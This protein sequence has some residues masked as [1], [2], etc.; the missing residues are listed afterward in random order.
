MT[1]LGVTEKKIRVVSG[2]LVFKAL[3]WG[4]LGMVVVVTN[5]STCVVGYVYR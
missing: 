2:K 1:I 5:P 4:Q 3:V